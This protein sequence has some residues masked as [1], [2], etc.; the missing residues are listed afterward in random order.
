MSGQTF[1]DH[2]KGGL[3]AVVTMANDC[4]DGRSF[5]IAANMT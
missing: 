3:D 1:R 5:G 4:H 2:E